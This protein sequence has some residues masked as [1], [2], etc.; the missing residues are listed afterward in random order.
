M[1]LS[2]RWT[3]RAADDLLAIGRYIAKD[4]R[5]AARRWVARLKARATDAAKSPSAGRQVPELRQEDLREVIEGSYRIV[6]RVMPR[7]IEV[8]AVFEGHRTLKLD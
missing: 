6:Y 5:V 7:R 4:D 3:R 8:L 1:T 2:V